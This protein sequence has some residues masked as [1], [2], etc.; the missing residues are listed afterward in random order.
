MKQKQQK[1]DLADLTDYLR[2]NG[3]VVIKGQAP[4]WPPILQVKRLAKTRRMQ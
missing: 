1:I 2:K 3:L 4:G